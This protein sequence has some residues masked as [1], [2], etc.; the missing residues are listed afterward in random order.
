VHLE[1]YL[2]LNF[3]I[4]K[5]PHFCDIGSL[6]PLPTSPRT[7]FLALK[8]NS[9]GNLESWQ[10][11]GREGRVRSRG[12]GRAHGCGFLEIKEVVAIAY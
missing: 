12:R 3:E 8:D 1:I 2:G 11:P 10:V 9:E 4:Q 6:S 7:T 5:V